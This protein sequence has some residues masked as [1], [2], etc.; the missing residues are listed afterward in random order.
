MPRPYSNDPFS[1]YGDDGYYEPEPY[2]GD[3]IPGSDDFD[4]IINR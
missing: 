3:D 2:Y 4:L 1:P